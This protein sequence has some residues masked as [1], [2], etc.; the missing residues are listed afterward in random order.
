MGIFDRFRK[1]DWRKIESF[2]EGVRRDIACLILMDQNIA[3]T[4]FDEVRS[5]RMRGAA[6]SSPAYELLINAL[7]EEA[8]ISEIQIAILSTGVGKELDAIQWGY[9]KPVR[10]VGILGVIAM[11]KYRGLGP[12]PG[13]ANLEPSG[14]SAHPDEARTQLLVLLAQ[15]A[16]IK[17]FE[18]VRDFDFEVFRP[19]WLS[20]RRAVFSS[21]PTAT[22]SGS[23]SLSRP[24]QQKFD[25]Y[26]ASVKDMFLQLASTLA[27]GTPNVTSDASV[28]KVAQSNFNLIEHQ[29]LHPFRYVPYTAVLK[30]I[31]IVA[32]NLARN[33]I[34][35][36][37][38]ESEVRRI[39]SAR[40]DLSNSQLSK[41]L[42]L[43]FNIAAYSITVAAV[44]KHDP[45]FSM[46]GVWKKITELFQNRNKATIYAAANIRLSGLLGSGSDVGEDKYKDIASMSLNF[47]QRIRSSPSNFRSATGS[48]AQR[49]AVLLAGTLVLRHVISHPAY[50]K[51]VTAL[52]AQAFED[53]GPLLDEMKRLD[54]LTWDQQLKLEG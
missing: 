19:F 43:D 35:L 16:G 5:I 8:L 41:I 18:E 24:I 26:Q 22:A 7:S 37:I 39:S 50:G 9:L 46:S 28:K 53:L 25:Q 31:D 10:A 20:I 52:V 27:S 15:T 3:A 48:D 49:I 32:S 44:L 36:R 42:Q 45:D 21:I 30:T 2:P 54:P 40:V 51:D 6:S 38:N 11:T 4:T 33:F 13:R 1:S 14:Y 17:D 23:L 12:G 34:S 47:V 29:K